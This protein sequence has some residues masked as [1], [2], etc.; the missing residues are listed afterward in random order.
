M[1][2]YSAIFDQFRLGYVGI[3]NFEGGGFGQFTFLLLLG[4]R[5]SPRLKLVHGLARL[6]L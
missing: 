3:L 1:V 4:S 2:F 5:R 6:L